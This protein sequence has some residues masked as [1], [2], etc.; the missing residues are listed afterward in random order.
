MKILSYLFVCLAI[1]PCVAYADTLLVNV[2]G[3]KPG[4]GTLHLIRHSVASR[5]L[6]EKVDLETVREIMGHSLLSTTALYIHS[7]SETKKAAARSLEL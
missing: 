1:I 2:E 6:Q 4:Q 3:I 7:T 5:L